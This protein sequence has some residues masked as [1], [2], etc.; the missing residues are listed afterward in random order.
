LQNHHRL[1]IYLPLYPYLCLLNLFLYHKTPQCCT[2][3]IHLHHNYS[4]SSIKPLNPT[5]PWIVGGI[6]SSA[7][8]HPFQLSSTTSSI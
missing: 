8:I 5:S 6:C 3:D 7:V 2:F 1:S 4:S